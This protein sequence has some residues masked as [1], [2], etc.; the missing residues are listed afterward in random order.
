LKKKRKLN[1]RKI[2]NCTI[3]AFCTEK[4]EIWFF[5]SI[6]WSKRNLANI[7]MHSVMLFLIWPNIW[8]FYKEKEGFALKSVSR[9][10]QIVTFSCLAPFLYQY[11]RRGH[12]TAFVC[13]L[14]FVWYTK[15]IN[16]VHGDKI[17]LV[18]LKTLF[19]CSTNTLKN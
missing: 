5:F 12:S 4:P 1:V 18:P 8:A 2:W 16:E 15:T 11:S 13:T 19:W 17:W 6:I 14:F 7:F 9:V 3:F 10:I